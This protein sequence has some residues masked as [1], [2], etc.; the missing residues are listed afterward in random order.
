MIEGWGLSYEEF[1]CLL[2]KNQEDYGDIEC[3]RVAELGRF[4]I[5]DWFVI[6]LLLKQVKTDL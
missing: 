4:Y 3:I 1:M 2:V 5:S 6:V